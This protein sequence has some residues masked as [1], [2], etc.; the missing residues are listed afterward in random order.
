MVFRRV[1]EF[2]R[3]DTTYII[4]MLIAST[5]VGMLLGRS[6]SILKRAAIGLALGIVV[7]FAAV[8]NAEI[9]YPRRRR[10]K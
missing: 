4:G 6:D 2:V 8:L 3:H 5:V 1:W 9:R 7:T 10:S